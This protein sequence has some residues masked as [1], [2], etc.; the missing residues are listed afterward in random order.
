MGQR[1]TLAKLDL[2][3]RKTRT[4]QKE[5]LVQAVMALSV[6]PAD[7]ALR[8][9]M[10]DLLPETVEPP[11]AP[12]RHHGPLI[13]TRRFEAP[14][15]PGS[16]TSPHEDEILRVSHWRRSLAR[17]YRVGGRWAYWFGEHGRILRFGIE[18]GTLVRGFFPFTLT[19]SAGAQRCQHQAL[20]AEVLPVFQ[21]NLPKV[22]SQGWLHLTKFEYNLLVALRDL[23]LRLEGRE[24]TWESVLPALLLFWTAPDLRNKTLDAWNAAC[25]TL[26]L[27]EQD[28][29]GGLDSLRTLL[30]PRTDLVSLP[31]L[32][33]AQQMLKTRRAVSWEE[34]VLAEPGEYF[35]TDAF[36]G[37]PDIQAKIDA[38]VAQLVSRFEALRDEFQEMQRTR[39]YL[40][41]PQL[42]ESFESGSDR[43]LPV[44]WCLGFVRQ[45]RQTFATLLGGSVT[46]TTGEKT[47]VFHSASVISPMAT[48]KVL[49]TQLDDQT[50]ARKSELVTRVAEVATSLGRTLIASL[51]PQAEPLAHG[52]DVV[53]QPPACAGLT[54]TDAV[55]WAARI[56]L[57]GA[58]VLGDESLDDPEREST[59][60]TQAQELQTRI[61][62][63]APAEVAR[64]MAE[65]FALVWDEQEAQD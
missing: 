63:L 51:G 5:S 60:R 62:R 13:R 6:E 46:L 11:N 49:E 45:V 21:K 52:G 20:V 3:L 47:Q 39:F 2:L 29:L 32:L 42:L 25:R 55:V 23:C 19:L 40:S 15:A 37:A 44:E 57:M 50:E 59:L 28:R 48:L 1:E 9:E 56:L 38:A 10:I 34:V 17:T 22:V 58:Q 41:E 33:R 4:E 65:E 14:P 27:P 31:N 64:A 12:R 35:P 16:G 7:K 43:S 61:A 8:I 30:E 54:V 36:D 24:W 18:S 26:R 53:A